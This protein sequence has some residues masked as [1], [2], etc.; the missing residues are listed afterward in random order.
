MIHKD[1]AGFILKQSI[2]DHIRLAK[3][4]IKYTKLTHENGAIVALDQE[5]AYDKIQHDYLW[6]ALERFNVP[7]TF[8]KQSERSTKT[9]IPGSQ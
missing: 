4:I 6:D 1:Q 2:F 5:K 8:I 9:H 3:T 7:Q